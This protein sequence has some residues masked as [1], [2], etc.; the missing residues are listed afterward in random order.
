MRVCNDEA[1][2]EACGSSIIIII[3]IIIIHTVR[4]STTTTRPDPKLT[5]T[6]CES[7][8]QFS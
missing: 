6:L 2:A 1:V 4:M 5:I 3:I 7:G 8:L